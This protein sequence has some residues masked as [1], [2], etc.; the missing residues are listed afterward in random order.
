MEKQPHKEQSVLQQEIMDAE[1]KVKIG[2]KYSH[3][4]DPQKIYEVIGFGFLESNDELCVIYRATYGNQIT[5]LRPLSSWLDIIELN[6]ETVPRFA[7]I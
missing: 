6:G 3:Y 7:L 1:T 2:A 4:K 5:F